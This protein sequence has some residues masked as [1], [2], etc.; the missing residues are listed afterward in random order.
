MQSE[1]KRLLWAPVFIALLGVGCAATRDL[2]TQPGRRLFVEKQLEKSIPRQLG[3]NEWKLTFDKSDKQGNAKF[4]Y[5]KL[6]GCGHQTG[7][8]T[9]VEEASSGHVL[10]AV[11]VAAS[12]RDFV[13]A[14]KQQLDR[15]AK[16][17]T[18]C[19]EI[20]VSV[21]NALITGGHGGFEATM[22]VAGCGKKATYHTVCR[23]TD[24]SAGKHEISCS[25]VATTSEKKG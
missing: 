3:C 19:D 2:A 23:H 15:T 5:Y 4:D 14:A 11:G 8:V 18:S 10:T 16:F 25:N 13:D 7:Y 1:S 20:E 24:Y 6:E 17:D 22:G 21:L 9:L 12:E